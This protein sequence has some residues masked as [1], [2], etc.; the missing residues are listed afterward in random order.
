MRGRI[1]DKERPGTEGSKSVCA[2]GCKTKGGN[3]S[4]TL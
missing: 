2:E 1:K 3:N 4:V